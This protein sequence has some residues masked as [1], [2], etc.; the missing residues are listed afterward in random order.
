MGT[1]RDS[2]THTP[3]LASRAEP[4]RRGHSLLGQKHSMCHLNAYFIHANTLLFMCARTSMRHKK[5]AEGVVVGSA[6]AIPLTNTQQLYTRLR[7]HT[8]FC[9]IF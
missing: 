9:I 3:A 2:Q 8:L 4:T 6:F 5:E 7:A 1:L